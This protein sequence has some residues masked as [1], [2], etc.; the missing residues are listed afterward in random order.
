MTQ[1][2]A[3]LKLST[4]RDSLKDQFVVLIFIFATAG[5]LL[6]A[7]VKP[8]V[9]H[10]LVVGTPLPIALPLPFPTPI[11]LSEHQVTYTM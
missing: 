3:D 6:W 1:L 7:L 11:F 10:W 4:E 8:Y 5:L 9:Q 2:H